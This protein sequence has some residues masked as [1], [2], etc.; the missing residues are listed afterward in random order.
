MHCRFS[1]SA[2]PEGGG[3]A[4]ETPATSAGPTDRE[5]GPT[6]MASD[7]LR[8]M[9][10]S[11]ETFG[12]DSQSSLGS[13]RWKQGVPQPPSPAA[14]HPFL[15]G[16]L[17]PGPLHP[18]QPNSGGQ[19]PA[20]PDPL[21]LTVC[22]SVLRGRLR[23]RSCALPADSGRRR[24]PLCGAFAPRAAPGRRSLGCWCPRAAEHASARQA[25][26]AAAAWP[27]R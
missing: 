6:E 22:L 9:D 24:P 1:C 19:P 17:P 26:R 21:R 20:G 5:Q 4:A 7:E 27:L 13:L 2:G 12:G 18:P 11:S 8:P 3:R 23:V 10:L 14:P 16:P 15:L 25:G